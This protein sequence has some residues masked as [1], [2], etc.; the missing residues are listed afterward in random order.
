MPGRKQGV[1]RYAPTP[2]A[3]PSSIVRRTPGVCD[4]PLRLTGPAM[5]CSAAASAGVRRDVCS[6]PCDGDS[7]PPLARGRARASF[8]R[9]QT[10]DGRVYWERRHSLRCL[11]AHG[12]GHGSRRHHHAC[13]RRCAAGTAAVPVDTRRQRE[14]LARPRGLVRL[15]IVAE[16][17]KDHGR[18]R[19]RQGSGWL[20]N[21]WGGRREDRRPH[22]P[23]KVRPLPWSFKARPTA[24]VRLPSPASGRAR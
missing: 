5:V 23:F 18:A 12:C 1:W 7:R 20:L 15:V 17:G 16:P 4:T 2:G 14:T 9:G 22:R 21:P 10:N 8:S 11:P 3:V 13:P 19:S 6:L 24:A